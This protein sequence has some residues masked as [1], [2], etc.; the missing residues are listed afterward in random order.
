M[1]PAL[2]GGNCRHE[3]PHQRASDSKSQSQLDQNGHS[4][5]AISSHVDL[6]VPLHRVTLEPNMLFW[7]N[8]RMVAMEGSIVHGEMWD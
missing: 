3:K 8:C 1:A 4:P 6:K 2:E 5:H 7:G